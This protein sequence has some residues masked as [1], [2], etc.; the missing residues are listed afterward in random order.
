MLV[1]LSWGV[2][3]S[4]RISGTGD[5]PVTWADHQVT[6]AG[7]SELRVGS[8][9]TTILQ[10]TIPVTFAAPFTDAD[11]EVFIQA[12]ANVGVSAYPSNFT[13]TGFT[14]NLSAGV[15]ANF[16]YLAVSGDMPMV[17]VGIPVGP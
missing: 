5:A 2:V 12:N 4:S 17:A 8:V 7:I 6:H 15:N 16:S 13:P 14:L 1:L 3:M 10:T 9:D 11:Y